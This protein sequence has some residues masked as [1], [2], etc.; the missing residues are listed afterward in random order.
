MKQTQFNII[1]VDFNP[2]YENFMVVTDVDMRYVSIFSGQQ[3]K[4]FTGMS[5]TSGEVTA[6]NLDQNSKRFFVGD[7]NGGLRTILT[8]SGKVNPED[9]FLR[10]GPVSKIHMDY[11]HNL[12][13]TF[14][15]S[16]G[17]KV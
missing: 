4:V 1:D 7:E 17:I 13:L 10:V 8:N 12:V 15:E 16:H 14:S 2:L 11:Q 9:D 5:S 6:F 3:T